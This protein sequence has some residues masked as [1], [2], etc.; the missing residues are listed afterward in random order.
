MYVIAYEWWNFFDL[1]RSFSWHICKAMN[2]KIMEK[3]NHSKH[4]IALLNVNWVDPDRFDEH[5]RWKWE[6]KNQVNG[7]LNMMI[8]FYLEE[9][10]YY[11]WHWVHWNW[12]MKF[13]EGNRWLIFILGDIS[14]PT[15]IIFSLY[16]SFLLFLFSILKLHVGVYG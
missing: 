4:L 9:S 1:C 10:C 13:A 11:V 14:A 6:E 7:K 12:Q 8:L 16:F 3:K 15:D 5:K 2:W